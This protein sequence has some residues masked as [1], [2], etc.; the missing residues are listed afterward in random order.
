MES[1]TQSSAHHALSMEDP[2]NGSGLVSSER[3]LDILRL[4]L[5]GSP[6]AE[7]LTGCVQIAMLGRMPYTAL[8]DAILA[9]PTIP[10]GLIALFS[11]AP[12]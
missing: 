11:S 4:I 3:V 5:A 1:A 6:L 8:R 12:S 10:E 9:H 7:V 2:R